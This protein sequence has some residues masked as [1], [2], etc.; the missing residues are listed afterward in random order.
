LARKIQVINGGAVPAAM[1][2]SQIPNPKSQAPYA[3]ILFGSPGSGKGTQSKLLAKSLGIPQI[4]TGDMLREHV[5]RG[6]AVG[7]KV[8]AKMKAGI[9]VK[10]YVVNQ[11]V[12]ERLAQPDAA[13]GFILDGYPRTRAQAE[14]LCGILSP[15][16]VQAVVIHLVVDYNVIIARLTGR[17]QCP[18]C[19]TLYNVTSK[20][21]KVPGVCDLEGAKLMV[22]DDDREEVIRERLD[23]Y[24]KQTRPLI[25]FFR[26][27]GNRLYEI[28]AS[29]D[30]PQTVF[31]KI[32]EL[33]RES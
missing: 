24:E 25:D 15:R 17:R 30:N 32:E 29:H 26:E 11:L 21:P 19:G 27:T 14:A 28:D 13:N 3:L 1:N 31:G 33:I 12:A 18:V 9:L 8:E 5:R 16:G 6:N 22:R 2:S 10:D 23:E 20:P 7:T 4:S